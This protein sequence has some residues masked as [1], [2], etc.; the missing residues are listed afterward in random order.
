MASI[1]DVTSAQI[2]AVE[3]NLPKLYGSSNS[4]AS[5]IKAS[6]KVQKVNRQLYRIPIE[7]YPGGAFQKFIANGGSLGTG[8]SFKTTHLTAAYFYST[9]PHRLTLEQMDT[10]SDASMAV[11][12][13]FSHEMA[14]ALETA[15]YMDDISLHNDGTGWLTED[16]SAQ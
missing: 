7:L 14:S 10:T 8:H 5:K 2:E 4:L 9:Q 13:A 16:S 11:V 12:N 15:E 1:L 6:N 3:K